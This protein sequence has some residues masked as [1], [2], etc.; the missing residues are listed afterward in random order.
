MSEQGLR[1]YR[2][3]N[4]GEVFDEAMGNPHLGVA[5]STRWDVLPEDWVCP[6]CGS[7]KRDFEAIS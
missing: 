7:D 2:C 5:P 6:Q 4:C 3:L 1:Q